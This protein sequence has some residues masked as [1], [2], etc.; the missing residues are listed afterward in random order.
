MGRFGRTR[1]P[2]SLHLGEPLHQRLGIF[3]RTAKFRSSTCSGLILNARTGV[4]QDPAKAPLDL[5]LK[6]VIRSRTT[7]TMRHL[8]R[9]P[10]V[11]AH[12]P[13]LEL[14]HEISVA[15]ESERA[16][17][18]TGDLESGIDGVVGTLYMLA[19]ENDDVLR[20][21]DCFGDGVVD[22][23]D[24]LRATSMNVTTYHNARRRLMALVERLR[25][26]LR[27]EAI[28]AVA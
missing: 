8:T 25:Q 21:L 26:N 14:E 24:I 28:H 4:P 27:D 23:R 5:Q 6:R 7:M 9:F 10:R 22:R 12:A 20:I 16:T 18:H 1:Y 13:R 15:M 3:E 11:A 17:G 2:P 19:A